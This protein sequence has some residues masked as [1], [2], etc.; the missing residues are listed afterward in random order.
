MANHNA[1]LPKFSRHRCDDV[2][3][4]QSRRKSP[5]TSWP[6]ASLTYAQERHYASCKKNF[7]F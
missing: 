6:G 7:C 1:I 4:D 5:R 3:D 2:A